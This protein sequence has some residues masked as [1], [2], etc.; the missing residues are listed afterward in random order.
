MTAT[1]LRTAHVANEY[2]LPVGTVWP[3]TGIAEA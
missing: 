2:I 1:R 3:L